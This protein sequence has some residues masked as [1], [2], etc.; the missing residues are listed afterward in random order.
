MASK[1]QMPVIKAKELYTEESGGK[2][3]NVVETL[4]SLVDAV[5]TPVQKTSDMTL[6]VGVDADGRL[7]TTAPDTEFVPIIGTSPAY[8]HNVPNDADDRADVGLIGGH[9]EIDNGAISVGACDAIVSYDGESNEIDRYTVPSAIRAMDGW[10]WGANDKYNYVDVNSGIYHKVVDRIVVD[11]TTFAFDSVGTSSTGIKYGTVRKSTL[12]PVVNTPNII[13]DKYATATDVPRSSGF[14]RAHDHVIYIYDNA[15]TDVA[16]ANALAAE[17]NITIFYEM[18]IESTA[19]VSEYLP[20]DNTIAVSPGGI[21]V[22][23]QQSDAAVDIPNAVTYYVPDSVKIEP[24]SGIYVATG[25]TSYAEVSDSGAAGWQSAIASC[26]P[27]DAFVVSGTASNAANLI[28]FY[29]SDSH[30]LG[31]GIADTQSHS[32]ELMTAPSGTEKVVYNDS[33]RSGYIQRLPKSYVDAI[34]NIV[35]KE[36]KKHLTILVF[37]HSYSADSWQYVPFILKNYGITC[38]IYIYYRGNDSIDRLVAEWTETGETGTDAWGISHIRRMIHIDTRKADRWD[39]AVTGYSPKRVLEI[40][41]DP[42]CGFDGWDI[43]NLQTAP[44][45]CYFVADVGSGDPRKGPEPWIRKTIELIEASYHKPYVLAWFCVYTRIEAYSGN[46]SLGYPAV[47]SAEFDNRVDCLRAAE[48]I[49]RSEPIDMVIPAAA[50]VFNARTNADMT[51]PYNSSTGKGISDSGNLWYTDHVHL[52]HGIPCY[53]TN[54]TVVQSIFDKFYPGMSVANDS[55]T[56]TDAIVGM[57]GWN[58]P[59][60]SIHGNVR[61]TSPE[62]YRLARKAAICACRHPF[63]IIPIRDGE[64][65][66]QLDFWDDHDGERYWADELITHDHV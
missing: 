1:T 41:N 12:N 42:N 45:E 52:Q 56:L 22:F 64:D 19:D 9:V 8:T 32:G 54:L 66:T 7:W 21:V 33:T 4:K 55:I 26:N 59:M 47:T 31:G 35:T 17:N 10:G 20:E 23:H 43:I 30:K 25:D 49:F 14:V 16:T 63:D 36:H 6:P 3:F 15:L 11:G 53:I 18:K 46:V 60:P 48:T 24:I 61:E 57:D 2:W 27:G 13:S 62:L 65:D 34:D 29:D 37:G 28:A 51:A 38:E 5:P 50:A 58:C 39:N 40:A 44:T